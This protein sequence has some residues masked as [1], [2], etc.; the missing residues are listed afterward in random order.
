MI[1]NLY[2]KSV[3]S[4]HIHSNIG[5]FGYQVPLLRLDLP[6]HWPP[7]HRN[8][9]RSWFV[10]FSPPL[11][12]FLEVFWQKDWLP[13]NRI[14][15]S[16][17]YIYTSR[18][19]CDKSLNCW[20]ARRIQLAS[21]GNQFPPTSN[22]P[23]CTSPEPVHTSKTQSLKKSASAPVASWLAVGTCWERGRERHQVGDMHRKSFLFSLWFPTIPPFLRR[24]HQLRNFSESTPLACYP[25]FVHK[26]S[27]KFNGH[28]FEKRY[29]S[30]RTQDSRI[31][32]PELRVHPGRWTAGTYKSP[33]K[34]KDQEND[35]NQTFMIMFPV[36]LQGCI[37]GVFS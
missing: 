24:E 2:I 11:H 17:I 28:C 37:F 14:S 13:P 33:M 22:Y 35:L 19:Q 29:G 30:G 1:P 23:W 3:V 15:C 7:N 34:R 20:I 4:P 32:Q 25:C 21:S 6:S 27:P 31:N 5:C 9:I 36:N 16:F 12:P 18:Y 8:L 26:K 10:N